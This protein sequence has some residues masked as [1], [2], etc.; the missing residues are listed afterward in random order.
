[1]VEKDHF[2]QTEHPGKK[3][4]VDTKDAKNYPAPNNFYFILATSY[5][6]L[7]RLH[8]N[9]LLSKSFSKGQRSSNS[10]GGNN[11]IL[12]NHNIFLF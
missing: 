3:T 10:I 6:K 2:E 9:Q 12:R 4:V 5:F 1:M 11:A 8:P 7:G